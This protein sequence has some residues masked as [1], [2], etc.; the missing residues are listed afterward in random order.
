[1]S[2]RQVIQGESHTEGSPPTV[3]ILGS[4]AL[5]LSTL[6]PYLWG[7]TGLESGKVRNSF[8]GK[9]DIRPL[10]TSIR[11]RLGK[12]T[13]GSE[14]EGLERNIRLSCLTD[15]LSFEIWG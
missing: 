15:E 9:Y 12:L 14:N 2:S 10:G 1:M 5:V 13:Q 8:I 11:R 7:T 6:D 3:R 4:E